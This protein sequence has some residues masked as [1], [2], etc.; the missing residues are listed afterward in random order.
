MQP[1]S[2]R[3]FGRFSTGLRK[4]GAQECTEGHITADAGDRVE[5]RDSH[6]TIQKG[7]E[8]SACQTLLLQRSPEIFYEAVGSA[9]VLP[10]AVG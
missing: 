9:D 4:P 5:V 6:N 7:V 8:S 10:S 3:K 2:S 1:V